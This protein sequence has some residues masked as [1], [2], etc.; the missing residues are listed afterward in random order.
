MSKLQ[1]KPSVLKREHPAVQ[2]M[3]FITFVLF[4]WVIFALLDPDPDCEFQSRSREPIESRSNSDL[5]I[6]LAY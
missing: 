6:Q 1:D 4:E 5:R 2:K 3:K